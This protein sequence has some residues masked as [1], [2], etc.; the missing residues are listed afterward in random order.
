MA[1]EKDSGPGG[2]IGPQ[3]PEVQPDEVLVEDKIVRCVQLE[4]L[5][6][7]DV[8]A[9]PVSRGLF[10]EIGIKGLFNR[11]VVIAHRD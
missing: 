1:I 6:I 11:L 3:I 2:L 10:I 5:T 7:R 4:H 9:C 8:D